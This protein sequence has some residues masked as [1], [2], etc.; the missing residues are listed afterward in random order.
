VAAQARHIDLTYYIDPT[1]LLF[2]ENRE[3]VYCLHCVGHT[4]VQTIKLLFYCKQHFVRGISMCGYMHR[5]DK[6]A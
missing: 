3:I 6:E 1:L 2:L 4:K 5:L